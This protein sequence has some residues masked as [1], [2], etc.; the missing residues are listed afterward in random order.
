MNTKILASLQEVSLLDLRIVGRMVGVASPTKLGRKV[1]T[2]NIMAIVDGEMCPTPPSRKGKPVTRNTLSA[3]LLSLTEELRVL[4]Q[5]NA[6]NKGKFEENQKAAHPMARDIESY[7]AVFFTTP[8]GVAC[9]YDED[10]HLLA[11]LGVMT[12]IPDG[13]TVTLETADH[14]IRAI[15]S[16]LP[17][18]YAPPPGWNHISAPATDVLRIG[19]FP[20]RVGGITVISGESALKIAA[21]LSQDF[22]TVWAVGFEQGEPSGFDVSRE[23]VHTGT[24]EDP[25]YLDFVAARAQRCAEK[26]E[27]V[28]LAAIGVENDVPDRWRKACGALNNGGSVTLL[29]TTDADVKADTRIETADMTEFYPPIDP[30]RSVSR[31]AEQTQDDVYAAMKKEIA[32]CD[33]QT[34]WQRVFCPKP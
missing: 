1:L 31:Y 3:D 2:D 29:I 15:E 14:K 25:A 32:G 17:S 22:D 16:V 5:Q 24:A 34:A 19:G 12:G 11:K 7:D 33:T 21:T 10:F 9:A 6:A 27:R 23:C 28:L 18:A 4:I 26:G 20:V 13:A 30:I 8:T